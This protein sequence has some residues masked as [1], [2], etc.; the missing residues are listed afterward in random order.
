MFITKESG[1]INGR[2]KEGKP[3]KESNGKLNFERM[4]G[5]SRITHTHTHTQHNSITHTCPFQVNTREIYYRQS[6]SVCSTS[7]STH[8]HLPPPS[9]SSS[10]SSAFI[11]LGTCC[12]LYNNKSCHQYIFAETCY[13][14]T[15]TKLQLESAC[16]V[17][18]LSGPYCHRCVSA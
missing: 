16:N 4:L 14:L 18:L 1:A 8:I 13:L 9:C 15:L 2:E 7:S 12:V 6:L 3:D 5:L 10:S 17:I 11:S